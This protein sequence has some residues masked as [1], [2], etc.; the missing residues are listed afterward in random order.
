M[1]GVRSAAV[2]RVQVGLIDAVCVVMGAWWVGVI[3]AVGG[4][5]GRQV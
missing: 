1:R 2:V 3:D 4:C 5:D